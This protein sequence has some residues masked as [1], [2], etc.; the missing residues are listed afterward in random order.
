M[1]FI[2][3]TAILLV[4]CVWLIVHMSKVPEGYEDKDGFHLGREI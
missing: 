1:P 4:G 3:T 2:I